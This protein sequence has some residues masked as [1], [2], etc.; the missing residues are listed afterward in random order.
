MTPILQV[1]LELA[2]LITAAKAAGYVAT[3]LKQP[4]VL[5]QL[6]VGL[7]LGPSLIGMFEWRILDSALSHEVILDLAEIGV[8]FLMFVAGLEVD[9]QDMLKT[10]RIAILA[11][12]LGV[13]APIILG[14]GVSLLF[15]MALPTSIFIG[16]IL[17]ATSV[18]I[19]A[20]T[21]LELK[22]LRS[23]EGL[24][25][26]GA[27][28][29]DD[30]LV[31][32]ALS[33]FLAIGAGS[34]SAGSVDGNAAGDIALVT[35][36]MAVYFVVAVGAGLLILPR[37]TDF[38]HGLRISEGV[39]ALAIVVMLLYA[40]SAEV[41]G[42]LAA[43]TGAFLAGVMFGRTRH[44]EEIEQGMHTLSYA[45]FVPLFLVSIGL[46]ADVRALAGSGVVFA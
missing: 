10:G 36:R 20:Q 5:G 44:R 1:L 37:L 43:I 3:R 38:V 29:A 21:L 4:S 41:V 19:S 40:L 46:E 28:V 27:A 15:G 14:G 35:V 13:I 26:L 12:T 24:A 9:L 8:I 45:F 7:A 31:I 34:A 25:L 23:K 33:I 30:V 22:V 2:I 32:L 39:V 11:G 17:S 42:E 16:L 18:S 6:L